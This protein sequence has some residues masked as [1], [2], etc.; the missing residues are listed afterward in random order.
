MHA[1]TGTV[2]GSRS[3][4]PHQPVSMA[5]RSLQCRH[6]WLLAWYG[7]PSAHAIQ[8]M[9][10]QVLSGPCGHMHIIYAPWHTSAGP[11]A[12]CTA[13]LLESAPSCAEP[14]WLT[15]PC[16]QVTTGI[17]VASNMSSNMTSNMRMA[18]MPV[19]GLY[20]FTLWHHRV[21]AIIT[22][23]AEHR[24]SRRAGYDSHAQMPG[25]HASAETGLQGTVRVCI[26]CCESLACMSWS[27]CAAGSTDAALAWRLRCQC[28]SAC[29]HAP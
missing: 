7:A 1:T 16:H 21:C 23:S 17:V 13:Q 8:Q 2:S 10:K 14:S 19:A 12:S 9:Q 22:Q 18:L 20:I 11:T 5:W 6:F 25:L 15:C 24:L 28:S 29:C 3:A 26:C 27:G 4:V